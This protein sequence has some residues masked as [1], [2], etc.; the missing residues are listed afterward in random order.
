MLYLCLYPGPWSLVPGPGSWV[1]SL[2]SQIFSPLSWVFYSQFLVPSPFNCS[3]KITNKFVKWPNTATWY[4]G[5]ILV[6]V[7][8]PSE[9]KFHVLTYWFGKMIWETLFNRFDDLPRRELEPQ[10]IKSLFAHRSQ[11]YKT[12]NGGN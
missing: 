10:P 5:N 2:Q 12:Y 1:P 11:F 9:W 7:G 4:E 3:N 8:T 6:N